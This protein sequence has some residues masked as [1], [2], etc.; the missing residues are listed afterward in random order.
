[1]VVSK[2]M[3]TTEI[4]KG[5]EFMKDFI[6][7]SKKASSDS[8]LLA[9]YDKEEETRDAIKE[10]AFDEGVERGKSL[11]LAEGEERNKKET[12]KELYKNNVSM[13]I[14]QKVTGFSES[15]IKSICL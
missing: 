11:G 2:T 7:D 14:I 5:D 9:A 10:Q 15:K 13:N 3:H 4:G 6:K 8:Y 12:A 1:M